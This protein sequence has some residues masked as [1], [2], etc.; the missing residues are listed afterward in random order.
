MD[1]VISKTQSGKSVLQILRGDLSLSSAA[2]TF[3]KKNKN[4]ILQNGNHV[5]VR[6]TVQEGDILSLNYTD[7]EE[8]ASAILPMPL[9][10]EILYEDDDILAI[11]K[12]PHMPTHPSHAHQEDT[13]ANA[14][15]YLFKNRGEH[16]V[17]RAVN[18]LDAD[19]S[20]VVLLAKNKLAAS[21]LSA[22]MAQKKIHKTYLALLHGNIAPK[23]EVEAYMRLEEGGKMKRVICK[24]T[25]NGAMFSHTKY[26]CHSSNGKYSAVLAEPVTGRTHQLRVHFSSL[27]NPLLG[28]SLYGTSSSIINRQALHAQKLSFSHPL[29]AKEMSIIAPIPADIATAYKMAFNKETDI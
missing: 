19:T 17:F 4:G 12:P 11:N 15:A 25:D 13:L 2:I 6:A 27:G 24:E 8:D 21:A 22:Q 10:L 18:R 1:I 23:G 28:D 14:V 9:P 3:L 7:C 20:G 16:F 26:T 5:T 29:T